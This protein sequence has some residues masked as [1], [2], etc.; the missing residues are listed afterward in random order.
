METSLLCVHQREPALDGRTAQAV[1]NQDGQHGSTRHTP[2]AVH[3]VHG[4]A[5]FGVHELLK[6]LISYRREGD[7]HSGAVAAAPAAP[8]DQMGPTTGFVWRGGAN[9]KFFPPAGNGPPPA[10]L[11]PRK[12]DPQP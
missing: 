1:T 10:S 4:P 5:C 7:G 8:I 9:L 12:V 3:P 2:V 6:D 11:V